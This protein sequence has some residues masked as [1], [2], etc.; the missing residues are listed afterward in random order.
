MKYQLVVDMT[1]L[2]R[3]LTFISI[4]SPSYLGIENVGF[5]FMVITMPY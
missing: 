3:Q 4:A 2:K 1:Y 5:R